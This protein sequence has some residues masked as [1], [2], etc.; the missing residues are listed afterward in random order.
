[1]VA[2]W[3]V[4]VFTASGAVL[5]YLALVAVVAGDL[6]RAFLWL[7]ASTLVDAVDGALARWARV[8]ERTPEVSGAR[9]DDLVDYLT[10][11]FVPAFLL[12][13]AGL[14]P[15]GPTGFV[16]VAAMLLASAIGF[17]RATAKTPDHFFTGFPSY[18]N[19]VALYV[20]AL[21]MSTAAN[22]A[23]LLAFAALVFVP[24]GY[25]YPSR[26][27][28]L[29]ALTIGAG[30]VWGLALVAI[31][32]TLDAPPRWLVFGSLAY[33]VYYGV[34]SLYLHARREAQSRQ[35]GSG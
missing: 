29:R 4:H 13:H 5:A 11:V 14:L 22:A 27:P 35:S 18:W 25:V 12:D 28:T 23:W 31:I 16:V 7:V 33:P 34:L 30:V 15:P 6:R 17:S 21:G 3:L 9:L 10:F 24:I 26:T 32:W 19:I 1:V 2:A 8:G 20:A